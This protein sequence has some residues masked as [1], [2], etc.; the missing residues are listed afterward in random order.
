MI[1]ASKNIVFE[2][3]KGL[4]L[5]D[6]NYETLTLK[7]QYVLEKQEALKAI[8]YVLNEPEDGTRFNVGVIVKLIMPGRKMTLLL[9][10]RC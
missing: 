3:N 10:L 9:A 7:V 4:E 5:N 6:D 1:S 8:Y 2:L